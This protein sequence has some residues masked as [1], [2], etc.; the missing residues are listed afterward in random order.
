MVARQRQLDV[1]GTGTARSIGRLG[2]PL[3][4]LAMAA[5][6]AG[7]GGTDVG[8]GSAGSGGSGPTPEPA[9]CEPSAAAGVA[10]AATDVYGGEPYALGYPPHAVHGCMLLYVAPPAP[11]QTRG[12][13]IL[14]DLR[15]ASEVVLAGADEAPRRPAIADGL[16]AWEATSPSGA[17]VVRA[18]VGDAAPVELSGDFAH[19]GE[20]RVASDAVVFTVWRSADELG[21]TDVMSWSAITGALT[22][23][24]AGPGQQRFADVSDDHVAWTDFSEDPD[25]AFDDDGADLSDVVVEHRDTGERTMRARPGKQA[26]A[27]LDGSGKLGFLDWGFVHPEPKFSEYE[28]FTGDVGAPEQDALAAHVITNAPYLRPVAQGGVVEWIDVPEDEALTLW[29]R[30]MDLSDAAVAVEG[31]GGEIYAPVASVHF[32]VVAQLGPDGDMVLVSVAK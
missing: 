3:T 32:T 15:D 7:C 9:A 14:R 24:A 13:L 16:A 5:G 11:G 12:E 8:G 25:G 1:G 10:V 28:I 26:F 18:R 29:R 31:I 30:P 21:D 2:I 17:R 27:F 23:V 4:V 19:A 20:P 22:E 6:A